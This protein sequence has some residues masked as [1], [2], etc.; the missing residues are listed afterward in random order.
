MKFL[1]EVVQDNIRL[2]SHQKSI[3]ATILQAGAPVADDV[4]SQNRNLSGAMQQLVRMRM[5]ENVETDVYDITDLGMKFASES[6]IVDETGEIT[7]EGAAFV[8]GS[9]VEPAN[10]DRPMAESVGTFKDYLL[11]M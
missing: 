11:L 6:G 4:L 9:K 10:T 8:I 7:D 1:T 3:L 2:T 5:I